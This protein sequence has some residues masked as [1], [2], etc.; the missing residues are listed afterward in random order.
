MSISAKP[1]WEEFVNNSGSTIPGRGIIRITGVTALQPG[2]LQLTAATPNASSDAGDCFVIGPVPVLSG[3]YGSCTRTAMSGV[4]TCLYDET[5]GTPAAGA[6]WGPKSGS[7][8][9]DFTGKG[10]LCLGAPVNLTRKLA[11]FMAMPSAP[12]IKIASID[13]TS[14]G[15]V[16]QGAS[17]SFKITATGSTVTAKV[18]RG[19]AL[20]NQTYELAKADD[21]NYYVVNPDLIFHAKLTSAAAAGAIGV[22]NLSL[23]YSSASFDVFNGQPG[24]GGSADGASVTAIVARGWCLA[25]NVYQIGTTI[26]SSGAGYQVLNPETV[27]RVGVTG[28]NG[29]KGFT[30]AGSANIYTGTPGSETSTGYTIGCIV[31]DGLAWSY[32]PG[33]ACNIL[34]KCA[35]TDSG[36]EIIDPTLAADA[37]GTIA[38]GG[39]GNATLYVETTVGNAHASGVTVT[40]Y[41]RYPATSTAGYDFRVEWNKDSK[42]WVVTTIYR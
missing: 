26:E 5:S 29:Q 22:A 35:W 2:R 30:G 20:K 42:A 25:G 7:F 9:M 11:L 37:N 39:S 15:T 16:I 34:Y 36:P 17:G 27:V 28:S 21:G 18:L 33:V 32:A 8:K 10:W 14:F 4:V 13:G 38:A 23:T 6:E 3:K 31:R 24:F 12:A 1:G 41:N 40:A 19:I